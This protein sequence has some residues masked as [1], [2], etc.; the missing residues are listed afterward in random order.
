MYQVVI[1]FG[2]M[3][4][5]NCLVSKSVPVL[6]Y[7]S[8]FTTYIGGISLVAGGYYSYKNKQD[9][10][11]LHIGVIKAL[12]MAVKI[13]DSCASFK[14]GLNIISVANS[15]LNSKLNIHDNMDWNNLAQIALWRSLGIKQEESIRDVV[16]GIIKIGL[17]AFLSDQASHI[18]T[19]LDKVF[20]KFI[21]NSLSRK[22][23]A[24]VKVASDKIITL[25]SDVDSNCRELV[26]CH[27]PTSVAEYFQNEDIYFVE[28]S[29]EIYQEMLASLAGEYE[30]VGGDVPSI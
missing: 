22:V 27:S 23:P 16:S 18:N 7:V 8:V 19:L 17:P 6:P 4:L 25:L 13:Q 29:E 26:M 3:V 14:L 2:S 1:N 20:P 11:N 30:L 9:H 5:S 15:A 24:I 10:E 21:S 12:G 28:S